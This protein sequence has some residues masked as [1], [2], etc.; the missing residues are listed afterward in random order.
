[1]ISRRL[2]VTSQDYI[3]VNK[4]DQS[5]FE[6]A[7]LPIHIIHRSVPSI[8]CFHR[9]VILLAKICW[10]VLGF[11]IF[12]SPELKHFTLEAGRSLTSLRN[13]QDRSGAWRISRDSSNYLHKRPAYLDHLSC[14]Q[15]FLK[16][17]LS[18]AVT[19]W[20][21]RLYVLKIR[22]VKVAHG[23]CFDMKGRWEQK[24]DK[25]YL[26]KEVRLGWIG[27]GPR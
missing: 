23:C 14:L 2:F 6:H 12:K 8:Y 7:Y 20:W 9:S 15:A 13:R 27:S 18:F 1:M 4:T 21:I 25:F 10:T 22:F 16:H 3:H 17:Q 24:G 5:V 19:F 11:D 26:R